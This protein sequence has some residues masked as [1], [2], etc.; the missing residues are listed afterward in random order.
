M[1][2]L[3]ER[4]RVKKTLRYHNSLE[5]LVDILEKM[6]SEPLE[7]E[8][9]HIRKI[10]D[11]HYILEPRVS[12]GMPHYSAGGMIKSSQGIIVSMNIHSKSEQLQ[13]LCF[14]GALHKGHLFIA[15][16]FTIALTG[17]LSTIF[18]EKLIPL[19]LIPSCWLIFHLWFNFIWTIQEKG[20]IEEIKLALHI[21]IK[22]EEY[23]EKRR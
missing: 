11:S 10:G 1:K 20:L 8:T 2:F 6:I 13:E 21:R 16:F 23:L 7:K 22:Q 14:E 9:F 3:L 5:S 15:V 12:L 17:Y 18:P 19:F 4:F